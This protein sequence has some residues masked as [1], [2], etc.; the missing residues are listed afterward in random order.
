MLA[1]TPIQNIILSVKYGNSFHYNALE[2]TKEYV[3][4]EIRKRGVGKIR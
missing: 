2:H 3:Y 4:E 1:Q